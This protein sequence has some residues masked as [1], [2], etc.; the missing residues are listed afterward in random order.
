MGHA[1]VTDEELEEFG[2]KIEDAR[3]IY[4]LL[5]LFLFIISILFTMCF[6]YR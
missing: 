2:I 5:Y 6:F 1:H 4:N 3:R